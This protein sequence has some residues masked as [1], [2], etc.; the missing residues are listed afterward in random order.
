MEIRIQAT[1]NQDVNVDIHIDD[2]I[3]AINEL[4]IARRFNYIAMLHND[5]NTNEIGKL[6]TQKLIIIK[7]YFLGKLEELEQ[8][9]R[10][11]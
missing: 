8:I 11:R 1:V 3:E 4:P 7:K 5:I 9:I 2:L 10:R 6:D